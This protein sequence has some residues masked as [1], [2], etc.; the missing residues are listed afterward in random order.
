MRTP[1]HPT[2][3][4]KKKEEDEAFDP[5]LEEEEDESDSDDSMGGSDGD[6]DD[7]LKE[8]PKVNIEF[9]SP[10]LGFQIYPGEG[11]YKAV[12]S[13]VS[14]KLRERE[15]LYPGM[16]ILAIDTNPISES[17]SFEEIR[18]MLENLRFPSFIE[19]V[20]T[21]PSKHRCDLCYK[22][23]EEYSE[24]VI[25]MVQHSNQVSEKRFPSIK[26]QHARRTGQR[27]ANI[28]SNASE[29]ALIAARQ[30]QLMFDPSRVGGAE[31]EQKREYNLTLQRNN[32]HLYQQHVIQYKIA[33]LQTH[34]E[35][36]KSNPDPAVQ[37]TAKQALVYI[38][39][40]QADLAALRKV[41]PA[42]SQHHTGPSEQISAQSDVIK[43]QL[44]GSPKMG[45]PKNVQISMK[46]NTPPS[47]SPIT[48][49][50][51]DP[52][53]IAQINR[54]QNLQQKVATRADN[55]KTDEVPERQK[56]PDEV[57]KIALN[58]LAA[59]FQIYKASPQSAIAQLAGLLHMA[60]TSQQAAVQLENLKRATTM[61][62]QLANN[63]S[64]LLRN[65][66]IRLQQQVAASESARDKQPSAAPAPVQ[67]SSAS[68][69]TTPSAPVV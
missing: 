29:H 2:G 22:G 18:S 57:H 66:H 68:R 16:R 55:E 46:K 4:R 63:F 27:F 52:V 64:I 33:R 25:H 1:L 41:N 49:T 36:A 19:F 56:R 42:Q 62:T 14:K 28:G 40:F 8:K 37:F 24:L 38:K 20:E 3:A 5:G 43:R 12:V 6:I 61:N 60:K 67:Q 47:V 48:N 13:W 26:E 45:S 31:L 44:G 17:C 53:P 32:P 7:L 51:Q 21:G 58:Q 34:V 30:Q 54:Q 50:T 39:R 65:A 59:L 35:A 15:K 10:D 23:F 11:K 9:N 69:K